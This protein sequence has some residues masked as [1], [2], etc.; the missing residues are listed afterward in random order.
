MSATFYVNSAL[1]GSSRSYMT[2]GQIFQLANAGNE[3]GSHTLHHPVLSQVSEQTAV[4]E[5]CGDR[6]NLIQRGLAPVTS[7]AYPSAVRR[8][9]PR[10]VRSCGFS[11]ARAVGGSGAL[12]GEN[13]PP[14]E[15][16]KVRT[17]EAASIGMTAQELERNVTNAEQQSGKPWIILVFHDICATGC[18]A[19]ESTKPAIF[20]QLLDWLEAQRSEGN[21][22]VR[23]VGDV[24]ANGLQAS[25]SSPHTT[26]ACIPSS[27]SDSTSRS[28]AVRVSLHVTGAT[29]S[30]DTYY[31]TDGTNPKNSASWQPYTHP[32]PVSGAA[33]VRFYSRDA[34]GHSEPVHSQRIRAPVPTMAGAGGPGQALGVTSSRR[35]VAG[36]S[37]VLFVVT[38]LG[39]VGLLWRS[40]SRR[41]MQ[42]RR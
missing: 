32:F 22:A 13:I 33:T 28:K 8:D 20:G 30:S 40:A 4:D 5:I 25:T 17:A 42:P 31:T 19:Q 34:A 37:L 15:P 1:V 11:S 24:I 23:T 12:P 2:W 36:T 41:R 18:T 35:L 39:G 38:L 29:G 9:P 16:F 6:R 10:A 14:A 26:A 21:V 3:I 7:F 27:C